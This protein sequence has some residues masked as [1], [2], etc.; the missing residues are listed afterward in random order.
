MLIIAQ[1]L[2]VL[3]ARCEGAEVPEIS[4][5]AAV[6]ISADTGEIVYEKNCREKL[7]MASTTK[8]MTALLCIESG[9]LDVPFVVDSEAI[10]VEGSS[11]GLQE[12]DIVTKYAL[13]CGMLL[14]SGNDAANA[15]A[16]R[17]A[18]SIPAF[19]E[20]MNEKARA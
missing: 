18:G 16:V 11:M 1:P 15:A 3:D 8:I 6:V 17:I 19:A 12:G 13:C 7:P 2:Y 10:K 4:A 5:K 20:L 9:G 14:P